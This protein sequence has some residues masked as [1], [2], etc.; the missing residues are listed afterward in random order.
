MS[1]S[2]D[3][4]DE[5]EEEEEEEEETSRTLGSVDSGGTTEAPQPLLQLAFHGAGTGGASPLSLLPL[6]SRI[7]A[8]A[9]GGP[10]SVAPSDEAGRIHVSQRERAQAVSAMARARSRSFRPPGASA[11]QHSPVVARD[12]IEPAILTEEPAVRMWLAR[13]QVALGKGRLARERAELLTVARIDLVPYPSDFE[14]L[15]E[16]AAALAQQR[17]SIAP[18]RLR[19]L[20]RWWAVVG[21]LQRYGLLAEMR[22]QSLKSCGLLDRVGQACPF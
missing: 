17:R 2:Q 12:L 15:A 22:V 11:R 10:A 1:G 3:S 8:F 19:R 21:A 5:E 4:D 9:T 6:L 13:Q 7:P 18:H 20:R 16:Q 14:V